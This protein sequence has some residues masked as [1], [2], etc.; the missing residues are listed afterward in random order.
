MPGER[1]RVP[2]RAAL[3]GYVLAVALPALTALLLIPVRDEHPQTVA[4]VLVLPVVI[5]AVRGAT[6][7]A[8]LS[9]LV[10]GAAYAVLLTEPYGQVTVDETDDVVTALTLVV[11][12]GIVGWLSSR[13]VHIDARA[14]AR[15]AEVE[16]LVG[17][18]SAVADEPGPGALEA[19][20]GGH[21]AGVL[22][23]AS[24]A[25]T[26]GAAGGVGPVLHPDGTISGYVTDL[27][28][29]RSQLPERV[30][31]P[32]VADG[33]ELGHFVITP[34]PGRLTSFEERR[35]AATIAQILGRELR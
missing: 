28:P 12:A 20:A 33:H 22:G 6:G 17:F 11:V 24:A 26:P 7:P 27:H 25:W 5:V 31:L 35:T 3:V 30:V 19:A 23:A 15:E 34:T 32:V 14:A 4:V 21:I 9:A 1:V 29:D 18:W 8:V 2:Q 13:L 10:A 16:H